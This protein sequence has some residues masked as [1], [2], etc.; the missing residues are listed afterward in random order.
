[1]K[2]VLEQVDVQEAMNHGGVA[3]ARVVAFWESKEGRL[4]VLASGDIKVQY[5]ENLAE[6]LMRQ[7]RP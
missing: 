6:D 4:L 5:V 2:L 3:S 7:I 1:M